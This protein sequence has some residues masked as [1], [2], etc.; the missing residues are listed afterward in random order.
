MTARASADSFFAT[1]AISQT[2]L[3]VLAAT[4]AAGQGIRAT[5]AGETGRAVHAAHIVAGVDL[6][7]A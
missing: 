3:I 4:V 1:A 7:A 5:R 2:A 6:G